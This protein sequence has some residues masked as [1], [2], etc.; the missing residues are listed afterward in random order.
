MLLILIISL[1][2]S[3]PTENHHS[4]KMW[5]RESLLEEMNKIEAFNDIK[6]S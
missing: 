5:V 6:N 4:D 3:R 2:H 1:I